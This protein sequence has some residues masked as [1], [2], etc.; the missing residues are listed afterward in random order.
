MQINDLALLRL[1]R[2]MQFS[3]VV[4]PIQLPSEDFVP[5]SGEGTFAGWGS[6]VSDTDNPVDPDNLQVVKLPIM[7]IK[8]KS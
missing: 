4:S 1:A 7:S 6:I 8:S 5:L 3:E 2:K